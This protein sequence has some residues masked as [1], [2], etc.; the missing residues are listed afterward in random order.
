[1]SVNQ[2]RKWRIMPLLVV[3]S[4]G[5]F[6]VTSA[7]AAAEDVPLIEMV[8]AG[9]AAAV[10]SLIEQQ[11]DVN[12][13]EVDGTTALHWAAHGDHLEVA[14][15]LISAGA[16]VGAGN[17]YAVTPLSLACIN[18]SVAMVERL[19]EAGADPNT[20]SPEGQTALMTA[21]RTGNIDV[22]T[23]LLDSGATVDSKE[24]YREQTALMWAAAQGH[25]ATVQALIDAGADIHA[26]S[27]GD[28]NS[29]R[30]SVRRGLSQFALNAGIDPERG[31][32]EPEAVAPVGF[33]PLLFATRA[34]QIDAA[35][36]LLEAGANVNDM[37]GDGASALV[38]AVINAHYELANVLL[39]HGADPNADAQGWTALHQLVWTRKPNLLRPVP[40]PLVTGKLSDLDLVTQLVTHGADPNTRQKGEPRDGNRNVLNRIGATPFLLAAKAADADMMRRLVENGAD[41]QLTTID[42]VTPLM[43][44]AGVGIWRIGENVGTNEEALEAVT[45]AYELGNDANAADVNNDTA[46]HGAVHRGADEIVRFLMDKGA[47]PD[48]ANSFG[49]TPLTIAEGVWYPNTYKS[50]PETGVVLRQ[51]GATNPGARRPE[52]FPP[53]EIAAPIEGGAA[54]GGRYLQLRQGNASPGT[55]GNQQLER[56]IQQQGQEERQEQGRPQESG[57]STAPQR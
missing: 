45:L 12:T 33:S 52:D 9:N 17:R 50:E 42:G 20:A 6:S 8:K 2:L 14:D 26:R 38:V 7:Q 44:A 41:P 18:G 36:V 24:S 57:Q 40:F 54:G 46:L 22:V 19:L 55:V 51:L 28:E 39:E 10:R 4:L 56:Q 15:L 27:K 3:T 11:V 48:V 25:P 21:A 35:K 47:D 49:W 1:M 31:L 23:T 13:P 30:A 43:A 16:N 34:G 32:A 37:V 53:T 5:L 29:V